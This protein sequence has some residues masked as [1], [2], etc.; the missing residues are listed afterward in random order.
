[1]PRP[2]SQIRVRRTSCSGATRRRMTTTSD[3]ATWAIPCVA[4][5]RPPPTT[6]TT[7]PVL[8]T[9]A[10]QARPVPRRSPET[11]VR[12]TPSVDESEPDHHLTSAQAWLRSAPVVIL[13]PDDVVLAEVGAEPHLDQDQVVTP[14]VA[15]P[16]RHSHGHADAAPRL[17][18]DLTITDDAGRRAGDDDPV[19]RPMGMGL[20]REPGVTAHGDALDLVVRTL[21]E[22]LPRTPRSYVGH[23]LPVGVDR[24]AHGQTSHSSR[25]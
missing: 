10:A 23:D 2:P 22:H 15:D 20:Q 1:M 25:D 3:H 7:R 9:R 18:D 4:L 13:D 12:S 5:Q 8:A 6:P 14:A 16:V 11:G 21:V 17:E 19:L 24:D